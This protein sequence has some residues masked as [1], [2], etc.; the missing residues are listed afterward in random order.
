MES[1]KDRAVLVKFTDH[2]WIGGTID[3]KA[4][5]QVENAN[6]AKSG[7]GQY[8]KRLVPKAAIKE[9]SN[10]GANARSYH[11]SN[12]NPWL[13]GG[14]RILP[15][16]NF[17]D[18][19]KGMRKF[20]SDADA[21]VKKFCKD[22]TS[23]IKEAERTQG[24]LFNPAH[25]PSQDSIA[26][27]FG[28][29]VDVMPLPNIADWRVDLNEDQVKEI[30]AEAEAKFA[31]V[32]KEGVTELYE[33][34]QEVLARAQKRLSDK[35]ATFRDS[36]IGNIKELVVL[37]ARLNVTNDPGLETIRKETEVKLA[38]LG[39]NSLRLD[40][41]ARN[42]AA[43]DAGAIMAKMA[44][45]MGGGKIPL[46]ERDVRP[47]VKAIGKKKALTEAQKDAK[48]AKARARRANGKQQV[49]QA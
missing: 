24:K 29:D 1:L 23:W 10:I 48:N 36:L 41:V 26:G 25:Y 37:I 42:K 32:Q 27:K 16:A 5:A 17:S 9:R 30:Q 40:P 47:V 19:M 45:F 12:T 11:D 4:T 13:G 46:P 14:V 44:S 31:A 38:G 7:T 43:T 49:V 3:R 15:A 34:L 21:A 20:Q 6:G 18:Y 33:R 28:I 2:C 8:W 35:E 39:P 22:Y